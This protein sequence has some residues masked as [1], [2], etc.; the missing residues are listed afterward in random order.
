MALQPIPPLDNEITRGDVRARDPRYIHHSPERHE[1]LVHRQPTFD[2]GHSSRHSQSPL[3][4]REGIEDAL[5]EREFRS[6]I[7]GSNDNEGRDEDQS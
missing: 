6:F 5:Q 1:L 2:D 3:V 7:Q 4:G